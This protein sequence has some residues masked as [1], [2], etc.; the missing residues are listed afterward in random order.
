MERVSRHNAEREGWVGESWACMLKQSLWLTTQQCTSKFITTQASTH[1]K[2]DVK[3]RR[4]IS[5]MTRLSASLFFSISSSLLWTSQELM[6]IWSRKAQ[7]DIT[8]SA[9]PP[10]INSIRCCNSCCSQTTAK[11][12]VEQVQGTTRKEGIIYKHDNMTVSAHLS[13]GEESFP[14]SQMRFAVRQEGPELNG[15][16]IQC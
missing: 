16:Y 11:T 2:R 3:R 6:L 9:G 14:I 4:Q 13:G 12:N 1:S 7:W 15:D 10:L 5:L 8:D